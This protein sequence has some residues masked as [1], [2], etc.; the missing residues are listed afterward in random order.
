MKAASEQGL[1]GRK[2]ASN[3]EQTR[4]SKT[5][6]SI[7]RDRFKHSHLGS[8]IPS[9]RHQSLTLKKGGGGGKY[10]AGKLMDSEL[11]GDQILDPH[12][13]NYDEQEVLQGVTSNYFQP[14][15]AALSHFSE[16]FQ[17]YERF[18]D[19]ALASLPVYL[20]EV[21]SGSDLVHSA[22]RYAISLKD[23]DLQDYHYDLV[24]L[25]VKWDIENRSEDGDKQRERIVKLIKFLH[26]HNGCILTPAQID[27]GLRKLYNTLD[28][29]LL[30]YPLARTTLH[31]YVLSCE[32]AGI[33]ENTWR[34]ELEELEKQAEVLKDQKTDAEIKEKLSKML[35][36]YLKSE[37]LDALAESIEKLNAPQFHFELVKIAMLMALE[38]GSNK[39]AELMNEMLAAFTG[40]LIS[41]EAAEQG[42]MHL[43]ET[44]D[45]IEDEYTNVLC[46]LSCFVA[47]CVA[48][49]VFPLECL[50]C[51]DMVQRKLASL[52]MAQTRHL[53]RGKGAAAKLQKVWQLS[54]AGFSS[55]IR[56]PVRS[57][58]LG[59]NAN[60]S[61]TGFI[62]S[63][64]SLAQ[65]K[66]STPSSH[67][68]SSPATS[69]N[70]I[71]P[72]AGGRKMSSGE[73]PF[74][75]F[76][77]G[78]KK[79]GTAAYEIEHSKKSPK[80]GASKDSG[81]E[82]TA[83]EATHLAEKDRLDTFGM[84][85]PGKAKGPRNSAFAQRARYL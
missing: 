76:V 55:P 7:A 85:D 46:F 54:E 79:P 67:T 8:S 6:K 64:L 50:N 56:K 69:S 49:H 2:Q 65:R 36:N 21:S 18:K 82:P 47:R 10:T 74:V 75:G 83:E 66:I 37:D 5:W 12:D 84:Y 20:S 19:H 3:A 44:C 63:P 72:A 58:S 34:D 57:L 25:L 29:L 78:A 9:H 4:S 62:G 28:D 51:P 15:S 1:Q 52:I 14:S 17:E 41:Y 27:C 40:Q 33:T 23:L 16:S 60:Q 68:K 53:L 32:S 77:I 39:S 13:P 61:S 26:D 81:K 73:N 71:P 11:E 31:Q 59:A 70:S 43:L 42:I 38:R 24:Y 48:D 30:R 22:Q 45:Q 35:S 80:T